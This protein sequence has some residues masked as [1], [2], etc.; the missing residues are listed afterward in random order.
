M[1][2]RIRMH[3]WRS[4]GDVTIRLDRPVVFFVA[5]NGVGKTSLVDAVRRCLF[6]F[7][8]PRV[9]ARAVR[10]GANRAELS[11]DLVVGGAGTVTVTRT[12]TRT[13]RTTF[14][15]TSGDGD[16]SEEE[17]GQVLSR[18]WA[19][20]L[21]LADRLMFGDADLLRQAGQAL[22][23]REHLA[24]LLGV[25]PLLEVVADL[26]DAKTAVT[27]T[28]AGLRAE[29]TNADATLN[30]AAAALAEAQN[31]LDA[32]AADREGVR[33]RLRAAEAAADL[34]GQW[35]RYRIAVD[36]YNAKVA[37]LLADIGQMVSVDPADPAASLEVALASADAELAATRQAAQDADLAA[38]KA[39]SA[40]D[41]LA[42]AD[43]GTCPTCLRPL[44]DAE[45]AAAL[46]T[47]REI[48]AAATTGS[49]RARDDG[50]RIER[51]LRAVA[52]F[53]R[54]LDRLQPPTPPTVVD[55]GPEAAV[56]LADAQAVDTRLA[57]QV[58]ES[59][60]RLDT[61]TAAL[62]AARQQQQDVAT[63][64]RAARQELLLETTA[65]AFEQIADRYLHERIEPLRHDIEHRWKLV[66]G[67][68][69]LVLDPTGGMRLNHGEITLEPEDMSGGERAIAGVIVRLLVT[70]AV[71]R[72]PTLWFDEPLEH[73]DPRRRVSVARTL[74][75]AA[76]AGTVHQVV[77]TTYEEG[78][79]RRLAQSAPDLV[80][81]V[82]ADDQTSRE[83][84][85]N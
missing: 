77:A 36:A 43:N 13:G 24:D 72:I 9:A 83:P 57:E 16:M 42:A 85:A 22:P 20:D 66:F 11:V 12:L 62:E 34:A 78:I 49:A 27:N 52:E 50:A 15:A 31:A 3:D 68:D 26:H 64:E 23:V 81:V 84:A 18:E 51:H 58:G 48:G 55:P 54:R 32:L 75:Q 10:A 39:A 14:T 44:S 5:P 53:T 67:K 2:L 6:G 63:L 4:Y 59:R 79:A 29:A 45:R 82:Y 56:E 28:I 7:P 71:T 40:S 69:V 74:V 30:E 76:A 33:G 21:A 35:D 65:N 8:K 70:A 41:L 38:A 19:T 37:D 47:H 73:L 61:A 1:I 17:F 46:H 60:A 80:S 25:T